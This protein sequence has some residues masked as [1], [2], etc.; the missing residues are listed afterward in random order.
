MRVLAP[1][2]GLMARL[3]YARKFALIGLILVVPS[4]IALH[5]YWDQ[6]S[7]QIA[8]SAKERVGVRELGPANTLLTRLVRARGLAVAAAGGAAQARQALPAATGRV[9]AALTALAATDRESGAALGTG[10]AWPQARA[11][12]QTAVAAPARRGRR[13]PPPPARPRPRSPPTS[14]PWAPRSGSSPRWPTG[15]T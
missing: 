1:A 11:A 2:A 4:L 3:T 8:F 14:R 9:R 5:A 15:R 6:Q 7:G 13:G 12:A 10:K